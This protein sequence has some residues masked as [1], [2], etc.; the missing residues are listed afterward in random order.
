MDD[1]HIAGGKDRDVG[2]ARALS[3]KRALPRS[4]VNAT[5]VRRI[6]PNP[7]EST[8]VSPALWTSVVSQKR[9]IEITE[10]CDQSGR[11][12][13]AASAATG[14]TSSPEM[15]AASGP[16]CTAGSRFA[17]GYRARSCSCGKRKIP[18]RRVSYGSNLRCWPH[19]RTSRPSGPG[20]SAGSRP[21]PAETTAMIRSERTLSMI[22]GR[23]SANRAAVDEPTYV[24]IHHLACP[25]A[26]DCAGRLVGAPG[27]KAAI[28]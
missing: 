18:T 2:A 23:F 1:H 17:P 24:L 8:T 28:G 19:E 7:P 27:S 10:G 15:P 13:P 4:G 16:G 26:L 9:R 21:R 5:R 12:L 25:Y 14:P 3:R 22:A 20:A 6:I 11:K